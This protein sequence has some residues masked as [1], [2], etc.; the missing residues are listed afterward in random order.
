[1]ESVSVINTLLR[2][3]LLLHF[4]HIY[5]ESESWTSEQVWLTSGQHF[6]NFLCQTCDN[7]GWVWAGSTTFPTLSEHLSELHPQ[8][9]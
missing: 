1:M 9:Q 2:H 3:T 7:L 5:D 6:L 4:N 8:N